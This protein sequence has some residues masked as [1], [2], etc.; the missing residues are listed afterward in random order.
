MR[1]KN[2]SNTVFKTVVICGER[3]RMRAIP[4]KEN[5]ELEIH[6]LRALHGEVVQIA[7]TQTKLF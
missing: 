1:K 3:K 6:I 2:Q 7:N 5:C 4:S